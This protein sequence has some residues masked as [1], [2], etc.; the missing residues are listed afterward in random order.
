MALGE[1]PEV[2]VWSAVVDRSA[3]RVHI[4]WDTTAP[5]TPLGRQRGLVLA[6]APGRQKTLRK[7]FATSLDEARRQAEAAASS[8]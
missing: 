1:Q 6:C 5:V 4:E 2:E 3:G 8:L 7:G